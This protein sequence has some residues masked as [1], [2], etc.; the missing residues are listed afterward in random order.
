MTVCYKG[1]V[2]ADPPPPQLWSKTTFLHFLGP[3]PKV[4]LSFLIFKSTKANLTLMSDS[5]N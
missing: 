1:V 5:Q 2:K 4:V 3:F